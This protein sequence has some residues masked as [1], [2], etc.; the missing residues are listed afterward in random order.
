RAVGGHHAVDELA[1]APLAL[2][3]TQRAAEVL[4]GHDVGRVG[5]P[6]AGELHAALLEVHRPVAPVGHH[7]VAALPRH[8][9]VR[10][11]PLGRPHPLDAYRRL[12]GGPVAARAV[13]VPI[14]VAGA[15]RTGSV[16]PTR[17]ARTR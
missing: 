11:H 5:A 14:A 16:A 10:V 4:G 15:V 2:G 7:D 13:A 17:P 1:Q 9:V 3:R 12:A 8:L 6:E